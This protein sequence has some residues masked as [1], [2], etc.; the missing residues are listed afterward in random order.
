MKRI[1]PAPK[2]QRWEAFRVFIVNFIESEKTTIKEF[3]AA[4]GTEYFAVWNW[5]TGKRAPNT[6]YILQ[7]ASYFL[8]TKHKARF[9]ALL[10]K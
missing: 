3:A 8:N 9:I 6:E 1:M 7:L 4:T 2:P 10:S 5:I